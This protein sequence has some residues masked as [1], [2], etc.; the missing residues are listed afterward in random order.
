MSA[1]VQEAIQELIL[2]KVLVDLGFS[3]SSVSSSN[4]CGWKGVICNEIGD[5]K[6]LKMS[7]F[8]LRG[9]LAT[10]IGLLIGIEAIDLGEKK[11]KAENIQLV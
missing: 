5:L 1:E 11:I 10:E 8:S 2:R 6:E 7:R 9:F 3:T 4:K